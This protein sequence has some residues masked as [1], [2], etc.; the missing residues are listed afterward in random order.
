M[1]SKRQAEEQ[2][3]PASSKSS[4]TATNDVLIDAAELAHHR[5][6]VP[7]TQEE[8]DQELPQLEY[9]YAG[10]ARTRSRSGELLNKKIFPDL[11]G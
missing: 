4:R 1:A 5:H 11:G 10:A 2:A 8:V 6:G 3:G 7:P 9:V